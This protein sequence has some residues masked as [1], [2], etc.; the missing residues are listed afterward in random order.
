MR[1]GLLYIWRRRPLL[2]LLGT[3]TLAN[4]VGGTGS[5]ITPLFVKFNLAPDWTARGFGYEAALALIGTLSGI[6]GVTGGVLVSTWG[7]LKRARVY[8]ILIP[9]LLA[10]IADIV[11]GLTSLLFVAAAAAFAFSVM[12]PVLNVHSQTI[13]QTQTPRELQGRVFAVRRLIAQCTLPVGTLSAGSVAGSFR[14]RSCAGGAGSAA[15]AVLH[16]AAVQSLPGA[17]GGQGMARPARRD[18]AMAKAAGRMIAA[19]AALTWAA[20]WCRPAPAGRPSPWRSRA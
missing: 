18:R 5:V 4:F 15:R 9:M 16:G 8:G 19:R 10:G 20:G 3:F 11:F 7:G 12:G 17:R 2:W 1:A 13:W 14:S 6:G